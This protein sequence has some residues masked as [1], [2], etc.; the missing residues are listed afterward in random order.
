MTDIPGV[1]QLSDVPSYQL[2]HSFEKTRYPGDGFWYCAE[3]VRPWCVRYAHSGCYFETISEALRYAADRKFIHADMIEK[4][5]NNL[6][7]RGILS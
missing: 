4:I 6:N 2:V 5:R 7:E 1:K 3:Q